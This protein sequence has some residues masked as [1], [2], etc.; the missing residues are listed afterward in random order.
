[1]LHL[2]VADGGWLHHYEG[3]L[4]QDFVS[5][6]DMRFRVGL[7]QLD[8]GAWW[9]IAAARMPL[10][11]PQWQAGFSKDTPEE[12]VAAVAEQ[13]L[14]ADDQID[15]TGEAHP[16]LR[17]GEAGLQEAADLLLRAGWRETRS[18]DGGRRLESADGLARA[19]LRPQADRFDLMGRPALAIEAGPADAGIPYWQA[20]FTTDAPGLVTSAFVRALTDPAPLHRDPAWM[21][22]Q[23]LIDLDRLSNTDARRHRPPLFNDQGCRPLGA[24][25][26]PTG[27][28]RADAAR[29]Q[30][31]HLGP[32][33]P[34]DVAPISPCSSRQHPPRR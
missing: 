24:P 14:Y 11:P 28:S 20:L 22:E 2:L 26:P 8:P 18:A 33:A 9:Q 25:T 32:P 13:L 5:S 29:G 15:W 30:Q 23:L 19:D 12:L 10:G 3:A 17:E 1:M 27:P 4:D 16:A 6:P 7:N 34:A 31:R 21:D